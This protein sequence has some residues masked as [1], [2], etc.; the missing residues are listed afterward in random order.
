MK[1]INLKLYF[2]V[3]LHFFIIVRSQTPYSNQNQ[4]DS[5]HRQTSHDYD[6]RNNDR[7]RSGKEYS[8]GLS[9]LQT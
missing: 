3:S 9:Q 8:F 6:R 5:S 1:V 7:D 4:R 2:C